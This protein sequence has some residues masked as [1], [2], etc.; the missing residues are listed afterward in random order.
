[1][2]E[3]KIPEPEVSSSL[4]RRD[5]FW[6]EFTPKKFG[7]MLASKLKQMNAKIWLMDVYCSN[8]SV[9]RNLEIKW[10]V[11]NKVRSIKIHY[12]REEGQNIDIELNR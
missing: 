1:M 2:G 3:T 9:Y 10:L 11:N 8:D 6:T 12:N 4:K 7:E 5:Y